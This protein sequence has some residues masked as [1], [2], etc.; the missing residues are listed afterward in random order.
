MTT[1]TR[2][3]APQGKQQGGS[4]QHLGKF[5]G[6]VTDNKDPRNQGRIRARVPEVLGEAESGWALPCVAYAGNKSG[7]FACP[8]I[9]AGVWLEFEAGDVSRPIW[10]GCWWGSN[11][12]PADETGTAATPD[13]KVTRSEEG[14]VLALHDDTRTIAI[15]DSDGANL[16]RIEV[17]QGK[18]TL[19]AATKIVVDAPAI[20]LAA[21]AAHPGVFGDQLQRYLAQLV[22]GFNFHMHPGQA[23]ALGPVTPAPPAPQLAPPTPDLLSRTVKLG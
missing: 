21:G 17:R 1:P 12:Q 16:L 8:P 3:A 11:Q 14:L 20:E 15:S 23:T 18:V 5:R 22:Q 4:H 2:V 10:T 9:G 7:S 19:K 6:S 13:V